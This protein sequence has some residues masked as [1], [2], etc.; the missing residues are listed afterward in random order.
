MWAEF[1]NDLLG[2]VV[3]RRYKLLRVIGEG[4]MGLVF[5]A[6]QVDLARRV[7]VK[8]LLDP[9]PK[10]LDRF[11]IE[12]RVTANLGCVNVVT[13]LD[14]QR[15]EGDEPPILVMELLEGETLM[16]LLEREP[17]L[18]VARAS[19]I[20]AQ[21]LVGLSAAHRAGILHR[22]VKPSNV[23]LVPSPFGDVVKLVDFGIAKLLVGE[24]GVKTTTG[25]FP[26]T[27]AY[28]APEQLRLEPLDA[29]TDVHGV[30]VVLY[31]MLA[32]ERP[33]PQAIVAELSVAILR[34]PPPPLR[35]HRPDVS[36]E[37]AAVVM[38]A[39]CKKRDE[40]WASADEM[41]SALRPWLSAEPAV[42]V[43]L[44]SPAK[45]TAPMIPRGS[46]PSFPDAPARGATIPMLRRPARELGTSPNSRKARDLSHLTITIAVISAVFAIVGIILIA[47]A[48]RR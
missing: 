1:A 30:G 43:N 29:R 35:N 15:G 37:L 36:P 11:M 9:D 24:G 6:E 41:I 19:Q 42:A 17:R 33:Y 13:V 21:M 34:E 16:H 26:G 31:E 4:G 48:F 8:V 45:Q 27:P 18:P 40:R 39:L 38:R 7:A 28:V 14:F 12:A 44:P 32:G 22:D 47:L 2:R 3:G 46:R 5:E 10:S 20:A 25:M 23:F